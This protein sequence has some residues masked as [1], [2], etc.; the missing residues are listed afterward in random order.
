MK[1]KQQLIEEIETLSQQMATLE[2]RYHLLRSLIDHSPDIIMIKDTQGRWLLANTAAYQGVGAASEAEVLYKTDFDFHYPELAEQYAADEQQVASSRHPM[3]NHEEPIFDYQSGQMQW[4]LT[5]KVPFTNADGTVS[6]IL[7]ISRNITEHKPTQAKLVEERNLLRILIDTIPDYIYVKDCES[8]FVIANRAVAEAMGAE[9]PEAILGK[10]DF[11]FFPHE[12]ASQYY[13]A[14]QSILQSNQSLINHEEYTHHPKTGQKR[15]VLTTKIPYRDLQGNIIGVVGVGRDITSRKQME[16]ALQESE[17]RYRIVSEI[18]SDYAYSY[19]VLPEGTIQYDWTTPS[20]TRLTGYT[21]EELDDTF[22][23]YHPED[24][25]RVAADVALTI[26]GQP[27]TGEY[28]I[29][30]KS[31]EER[32]IQVSRQPV[33]DEKRV[34]KFY[35]AAKDITQRKRAEAAL[36]ESENRYRIVSDMISDYAYSYQ[37]DAQG[38]MHFEWMTDS[39]TRI[40][41]YSVEEVGHVFK[42]YHPE[43]EPL[44]TRHVQETLMGLTTE[45]EY[46]LYNR[47]GDLRWFYI[48]RQPVW[49]EKEKR[50]VRFYGVAQDITERKKAELALMESEERYRVISEVTSDYAF[51]YRIL[52]DGTLQRSWTTEAAF[53]RLTGF[54][55]EEVAGTYDLYHPDEVERVKQD[56]QAVIQGKPTSGEYRIITKSGETRWLYLRRQAIWDETETQVIGFYGVA[57]DTTERKLAEK[58]LQL[59]KERYQIISELISDY[60]YCMRVDQDGSF[61]EEWMTNESYKRV[62]GY[63]SGEVPNFKIYHPDDQAAAL[64]AVAKVVQGETTYGEYRLFTKAGEQRW[65]LMR[66]QPVWDEKENRVVR[67]YG[68]AQ[69]ITERKRAEFAVIE[70]EERYKAISELMSDYAYSFKVN[71]DGTYQKEWIT[72]ESYTRVTGYSVGVIGATMRLYHPDDADK[73]QADL[74]KTLR[75]E[76]TQ[77]EYRI[78]TLQGEHRWLYL[79]R[80]PIWDEQ[81]NR[82]T[83]FYGVAQDITERKKAEEALRQTLARYRV[84]TELISDYAYAFAVNP[85]GTL[86]WE[87]IT[88]D[89]YK[90]VTGYTMG[91]IGD[92]E[93]YHPDDIERSY[94][95]VAKVIQGQSTRSEYRIITK[96]GELRW[97]ETFRRP[98]WDEAKTRVIRLYGVVQDITERKI[99]DK[100]LRV[101]E[102]RY[103]A[104][105]EL[106]SDFAYA[107]QIE[108]DGSV[109][110]EWT[111]VESYT[112]LTGYEFGEPADYILFH[113]DDR[114]KARQDVAKVLQG[115]PV[116]SEYRIITKDG[117]EKWTHFYRRP[118]WDEEEKRFTRFYAVAQDITERKLAEEALRKSE[119][120]YRITSELI[121]DY[122]YCERVETDGSFQLEWATDDAVVRLTGY[123]MH[124]IGAYEIFH[125]DDIEKAQRDVEKVLRGKSARNEY[126]ITTKSGELRWLEIFRQP[127]W[128]ETEQRVTHFYAVAQNI[129]ERKQAEEALRI[130]E[131]RYR[132]VTELISNYAYSVLVLPD[133]T[134]QSEWLTEDAYTRLTGYTAAEL[135]LYTTFHP[136]DKQ[137][138]Q[139]DVEKVLQGQE[140]R[141]EHRVIIKSGE[142]RWLEFYRRPVWDENEKR[143]VRFYAVVQDITERKQ[144]EQALR[145]SEERFRTIVE[146]QTEFIVRCDPTWKRIFVNKGYCRYLGKPESEVLGLSFW[147]DVVEEDK[148]AIVDAI[149]QIT[150]ENPVGKSME[151]RVIRPDGSIV[152][153]EWRD[154]AFFDENGQVIYYQSVG[155]DITERKQLE[156][157]RMELTIHQERVQLLEELIS[158]I[159]HDIRTPV[160]SINTYVYLLRKQTNPDKQKQY[161]NTLELQVSRLTRLVDDILTMSRLDKGT[162][163]QFAPVDLVLLVG[164]NGRAYQ[165]LAQEKN[166]NLTFDLDPSIPRVHAN[167][168]ELSRAVGNLVENAI[169]YTPNGGSISLRLFAQANQVV[170]EVQDTGIGISPEDQPRIFDRFYRTD[171]ARSTDKGG[172]GLGLAIVKKIVEAHQGQIQV[173][174]EVGKGSLFR[175]RLPVR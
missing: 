94:Q 2:E 35:G 144:A 40:T 3:L 101:S 145:E 18:I 93:L 104:I 29:V 163:L 19:R 21:P 138:A 164:E 142:V 76:P 79:R 55:R 141:S 38:K 91:E 64:E 92:Y 8:R 113:P 23:L 70:S 116:R 131:E 111:T 77:N 121:S 98:E 63:Q 59:S 137:A 89:S 85:D 109:I 57:Q 30:T 43:D 37:V 148:E 65:V 7:N 33:W 80:K 84:T 56:V 156:K 14:E 13:Q 166:I 140:V 152:W 87:W 88:D 9:N 53:K 41:G 31:G 52:P 106:M 42:L 149:T 81:E 100:A 90:R 132:A 69:D 173:E 160:S 72:E 102:E 66:R 134:L 39:F 129:T 171:K 78:I 36:R 22:C 162:V 67:F 128:D 60:A 175:I 135:G 117:E 169:H 62:T 50:V 130:S 115:I 17:Y 174:S 48:F 139:R 16:H 151:Y 146:D 83:R 86:Y 150:L 47:N 157:Q 126:R 147:P 159:S 161:L 114:E 27:T 75:G 99:A 119:E 108:P 12:E 45:G 24:E 1:T 96:G 127:V 118:I 168:M 167:D 74:E 26:Q 6:A 133:G 28:R 143:V 51:A 11:D 120:R 158:D 82:V 10:T 73:A 25:P 34:A 136:D 122:A 20:F 32:W 172:S 5:T 124:E 54:R 154:R 68:V 155:R 153:Q 97:I 107:M 125:P 4:H 15:W 46:R 112:R 71:P 103:R 58:A 49:D 123:T 95:D 170:I 61:H 105:S 44:A 165:H 110:R